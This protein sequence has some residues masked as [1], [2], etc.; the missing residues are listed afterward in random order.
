MLLN[1]KLEYPLAPGVHKMTDDTQR[2]QK[3]GLKLP[4]STPGGSWCLQLP[5]SVPVPR[6]CRFSGQLVRNDRDVKKHQHSYLSFE[7]APEFVPR[8]L[9]TSGNINEALNT[10]NKYR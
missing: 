3:T 2:T 9:R 10:D 6:A 7:R 4:L 1:V 8:G 5:K